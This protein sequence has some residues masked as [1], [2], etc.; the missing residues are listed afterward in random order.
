MFKMIYKPF[1][2]PHNS[3]QAQS[4][5][6]RADFRLPSLILMFQFRA[7]C[8]EANEIEL[9]FLYQTCTELIEIR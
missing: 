3:S 1:Y 7:E 2:H 5:S 8:P 6:T 4:A 9:N